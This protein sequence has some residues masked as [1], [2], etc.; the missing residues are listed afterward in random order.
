MLKLW[1]IHCPDVHRMPLV[2]I[3]WDFDQ[4]KR[5]VHYATVVVIVQE[6]LF[7]QLRKDDVDPWPCDIDECGFDLSEDRDMLYY[8]MTTF[9]VLKAT[10]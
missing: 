9:L 1:H 3:I 7:H 6:V 10:V 8:S 5:S 2:E 4:I